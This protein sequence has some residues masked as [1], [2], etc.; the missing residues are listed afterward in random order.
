MK[1]TVWLA[2]ATYLAAAGLYFAMPISARAETLIPEGLSVGDMSLSGRTAGEAEEMVRDYVESRLEKTITLVVEGEEATAS[3][4]ELGLSWRNEAEIKEAVLNAQPSGSLLKHYMKEKDLKENP[5]RLELDLEAD[6]ELV[7]AFVSERCSQAVT[8]PK[9]AIIE[10]IDGNFVITPEENGRTVDMAATSAAINEAM[11]APETE[12]IRI[13]AVMVEE[14]PRITAE[15]LSTIKDVLGTF[16]TDFS[17]SSSSRATNLQVG[18]GKINGHV[19]M[20][21]E[22]LSAYDCMKPISAEG[23]YRTATAYENG[24]SV[25]SIGGGVCQISTTLYNATL[26]AEL[27]IVQRQPHSMTVGYVKPS[28]D[29]AIAGTYKDLKFKNPYDTPIYVEGGTSG[30]TLTFTIYGQETRPANRTIKFESETLQRLDPGAPAEQLDNSLQPG[31]RVRVQ[32]SHTGL[33]SR[34]FK[35]VYVDGTLEERTL[36]HTDT[37]N[38]SKAIYRVGPPAAPAVNPAPAEPETPAVETPAPVVLE[39]EPETE[40]APRGPGYGPGYETE[41]PTAAPAETE[42]PAP[43]ADPQPPVPA[44]APAEPPAPPTEPAAPVEV[45]AEPPV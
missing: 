1:K 35:C 28:Q 30:R 21:G 45:P 16:S 39:T 17:S 41:A 4:E 31:Q 6:K 11:N 29:A 44:E 20:P 33:R 36:L 3:S 8:P 18:A 23:G 24:R 15:S 9:D 27:E 43:P 25:D 34:L 13:E 2:G 38:A 7:N 26:L 42:P 22:T 40:T 32:G 12:E 5:V 14:E 37:Y 10:K 19:L